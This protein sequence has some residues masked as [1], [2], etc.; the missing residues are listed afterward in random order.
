MKQS[1][2]HICVTDSISNNIQTTM[3]KYYKDKALYMQHY[4]NVCAVCPSH[5]NNQQHSA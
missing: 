5:R 4:W 3:Q 1:I 2:S